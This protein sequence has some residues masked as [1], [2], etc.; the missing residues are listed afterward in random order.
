[1]LVKNF[2]QFENIQEDVII[3]RNRN[4]LNKLRFEN[5]R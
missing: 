5:S 2:K 4:S 1:M 3:K